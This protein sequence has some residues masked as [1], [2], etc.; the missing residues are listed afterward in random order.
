[1][2]VA[3]CLLGALVPAMAGVDA[4]PMFAEWFHAQKA[5]PST[6][7]KA[8]GGR[9]EAHKKHICL[10]EKLQYNCRDIGCNNVLYFPEGNCT[11]DSTCG[12]CTHGNFWQ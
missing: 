8:M 5:G 9:Q 1:M 3:L 10:Q 6:R 11:A 7:V 2:A 12:A 4:A